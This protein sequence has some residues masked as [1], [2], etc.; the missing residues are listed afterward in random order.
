MLGH[1]AP[2]QED[3]PVQVLTVLLVTAG[4]AP[5]HTWAPASGKGKQ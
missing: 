1:A 4:A 2:P 5:M 3:A